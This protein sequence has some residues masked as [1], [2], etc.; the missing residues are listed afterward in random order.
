MR[1]LMILAMMAV[2]AGPSQAATLA[3]SVVAELVAKGYSDVGATRTW[4]GRVVITGALDGRTREIT[5]NPKTGEI[6][7]DYFRSPAI[8][9]ESSSG[10]QAAT[11]AG[12]ASSGDPD[13]DGGSV[14]SASVGGSEGEVLLDSVGSD[15]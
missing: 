1:S 15:Q 8:P 12:G 9:A 6:L 5:L 4:L 7:R 14:G 11:V 2:L 10:S 13:G 3:E